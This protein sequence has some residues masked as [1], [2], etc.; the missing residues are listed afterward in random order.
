LI[1]LG[2]L[3]GWRTACPCPSAICRCLSF[4]ELS[5]SRPGCASAHGPMQAS[6]RTGRAHKGTLDLPHTVCCAGLW[7]AGRDALGSPHSAG[8]TGSWLASGS[9]LGSPHS[10]GR[11]VSCAQAGARCTAHTRQVALDRINRRRLFLAGGGMQ[12][13]TWV[14]ALSPTVP[15]T[16]GHAGRHKWDRL[17]GVMHASQVGKVMHMKCTV[18]ARACGLA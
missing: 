15:H 7:L 14:G 11:A 3:L 13:H 17:Q 6:T 18:Q 4:L 16:A 8:C 9:T 2:C 5:I 10:V 12:D 1:S